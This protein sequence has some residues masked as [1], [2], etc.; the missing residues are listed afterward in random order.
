MDVRLVGR[1]DSTHIS[2]SFLVSVLPLYSALTSGLVFNVLLVVI[3]TSI[4]SILDKF[5]PYHNDSD[6]VMF[7]TLSSDDYTKVYHTCRTFIYNNDET[8][9]YGP[10]S[11][12][13]IDVVLNC[14]EFPDD[15]SLES[16]LL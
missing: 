16:I 8:G 2:N 10:L 4:F 12:E 9:S 15:D 14:D 6:N 13:D 7:G 1:T 11:L 3:M 5:I